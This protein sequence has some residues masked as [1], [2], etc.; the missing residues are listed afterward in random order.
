MRWTRSEGLLV[1]PQVKPI[2]MLID[3]KAAHLI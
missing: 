2:G 3:P 1:N